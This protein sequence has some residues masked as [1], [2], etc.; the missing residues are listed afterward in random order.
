MRVS[1]LLWQKIREK[2]NQPPNWK[3]ELFSL[4]QDYD[5]KLKT[6]EGCQQLADV[7]I[8]SCNDVGLWIEMELRDYMKLTNIADRLKKFLSCK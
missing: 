5:S 4:C 6:P 1:H 3:V 8:S 2:L 7:G